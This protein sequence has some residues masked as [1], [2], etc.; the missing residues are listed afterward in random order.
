MAGRARPAGSTRRAG[1]GWKRERAVLPQTSAAQVQNDGRED[2][3]RTHGSRN[4]PGGRLCARGLPSTRRSTRQGPTKMPREGAVSPYS[5]SSTAPAAATRHSASAWS[6][7]EHSRS[8]SAAPASSPCAPMR[9]CMQRGCSLSRTGARLEQPDEL[10][11]AAAMRHCQ[12]VRRAHTAELRER[13]CVQVGG[14]ARPR[15]RVA[16][17]LIGRRQ[18]GCE[19][20]ELLVARATAIHSV[21][22]ALRAQLSIGEHPRRIGARPEQPP[23]RQVAH[24]V[25]C[26]RECRAPRAHLAHVGLVLG[27]RGVRLGVGTAAQVQP[28]LDLVRLASLAAARALVAQLLHEEFLGLLPLQSLAQ[29]RRRA[30]RRARRLRVTL[31]VPLALR[32]E[33]LVEQR[34]LDAG[35]HR[36]EFEAKGARALG[37][38]DLLVVVVGMVL[39]LLSALRALVARRH[40]AERAQAAA[41]GVGLVALHHE[42][43]LVRLKSRVGQ[44]PLVA[45]ARAAHLRTEAVVVVARER[46]LRLALPLG[47]RQLR[48]GESVEGLAQLLKGFGGPGEAAAELVRGESRVTATPQ[49]EST[50][51]W[52]PT[53]PALST[54]CAADTARPRSSSSSSS[55]SSSFSSSAAAAPL[56][57]A[58]GRPPLLLFFAAGLT[59]DESGTSSSSSEDSAFT[60]AAAL[61]VAA[62]ASSAIATSTGSSFTVRDCA[63]GGGS[64][65]SLPSPLAAASGSCFGFARLAFGCSGRFSSSS[66]L[67]GAAAEAAAAAGAAGAADTCSHATQVGFSPCFSAPVATAPRPARAYSALLTSFALTV[68][69]IFALTSGT[70]STLS[71]GAAASDRADRIAWSM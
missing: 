58:L 4:P 25:L 6:S 64:V 66:E 36:V 43:I 70:S 62:A 10:L 24:L 42:G 68:R 27:V 1:A 46:R 41:A 32:L 9:A 56:R 55:S 14:R 61:P 40:A 47:C 13:Q 15:R 69:L 48:R 5:S 37:A 35:A 28:A 33:Y 38:G 8:A 50:P 65:A 53:A 19:A 67:A 17:T 51:S 31:Q 60:A 20:S 44:P 21:L 57:P 7:P 52:S 39:D 34:R 16:P 2:T 71:S 26:L 12:A 3:D 45:A 23:R 49:A 22:G 30:A 18:R 11:L 63:A 59:R 29:R 54:A